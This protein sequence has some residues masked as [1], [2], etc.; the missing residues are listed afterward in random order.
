MNC[1]FNKTALRR[2][3]Y[4]EMAARLVPDQVAFRV[5]LIEMLACSPRALAS[6]T[7]MRTP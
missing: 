7:T 1:A 3:A 4:N 6:P 5:R 2:P